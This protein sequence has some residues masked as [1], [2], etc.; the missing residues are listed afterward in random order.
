MQS[1]NDAGF[2]G[3]LASGSLVAKV[4]PQATE[5][6]FDQPFFYISLNSSRI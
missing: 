6:V 3:H 4:F 5:H 2:L 1:D